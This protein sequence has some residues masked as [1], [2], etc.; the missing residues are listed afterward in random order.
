MS[1]YV[2]SS[3]DVDFGYPQG[4]AIHQEIGCEWGEE[5]AGTSYCCGMGYEDGA[6]TC[7]SCGESL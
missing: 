5:N 4:Q 6:T 7:S 1:T 3:Y 2:C